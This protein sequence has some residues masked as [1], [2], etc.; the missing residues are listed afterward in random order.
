MK[1]M[2]KCLAVALVITL[3]IQLP[4]LPFL[5]DP[6]GLR[7]AA[8]PALSYSESDAEPVVADT[9]PEDETAL[10][11]TLRELANSLSAVGLYEYVRNNVKPEFTYGAS[12]GAAKTY[13]DLRG[14]DYDTA[15]LLIGLLRHKGIPARYRKG[16]V[17][18]TVPQAQGLTHTSSPDEAAK[19]LASEGVPTT[20]ITAQGKITA[21]RIERVWTECY[22]SYG[23]YRGIGPNRG[24]KSWIPLDGGFKL[25]DSGGTIVRHSTGL[26]PSAL[27][28]AVITRLDAFSTTAGQFIRHAPEIDYDIPFTLALG[29]SYE[30]YVAAAGKSPI[31][32]LTVTQNGQ[33]IALSAFGTFD[34]TAAS[35]GTFV[36]VLQATDTNGNQATITHTLLVVEE[37]DI[38][39]PELDV[40]LDPGEGKVFSPVGV[41]VDTRDDSG[42]VFVSVLVDGERVEGKNDVYTF[43]P[44][45][46]GAYEI[47]VT[48]TDPS[49]NY[50]KKTL[51]Y[52]LSAS[53]GETSASTPVLDVTVDTSQ[54]FEPGDPV[55]IHV[56]ATDESGAVTLVVTADGA[57]LSGNEGDYTFRPDRYG[58]FE[59]GVTATNIHGNSAYTTILVILTEGGGELDVTPP[60]LE[61][62]VN[63]QGATKIGKPVY[64]NVK[65]QDDSGEVTVDVAVNGQTLTGVAGSYVFTPD[66]TGRYDI[67]VTATD[68]SGN[69]VRRGA[70]VS[71][72]PSGGEASSYPNLKVQYLSRKVYVGETMRILIEASDA[73][74]MVTVAATADGEA[75]PYEDGVARF[76]PQEPGSF[77]IL[78]TA[79]N[80]SG[81]KAYSRFVVTAVVNTEKPHLFIV[82]GNGL[83]QADIGETVTVSVGGVGVSGDIALSADG[84]SLPLSAFGEAKFIPA[85]AGITTFVATAKD[86]YDHP[87]RAEATLK[88]LDP[89]NKAVPT[90]QI[91]APAEGAAVTA[92]TDICGTVSAEGLAYYTL[93][94]APV[95]SDDFTVI[96][97]DDHALS[98]G[99]LGRFDP[100]LLNNGYYTIRLTAIGAGGR[101]TDEITV[102]VQGEMKVG[103]FSLAFTDMSFAVRD[104]PLVV[105]RAYDSRNRGQSGD[106]GYG[107]SLALSGATLSTSCSLGEDWDIAVSAGPFGIPRYSWLETKA[108]EITVDWGNGQK[109]TFAMRLSPAYQDVLPFTYGVTAS[110]VPT[111]STTSKLTAV[112]ATSDLLYNGGRLL[113]LDAVSVFN[114]TRFKLTT[115]DGSVYVLS[116]DSGVES[117]TDTQ[118]NTITINRNG[119]YHSDGK[120]ISFVRDAKNRITKITGPTGKEVSYRYDESGNLAEVVDMTGNSTRFAYDRNHF[121]TDIVDPRGVR[122]AR[123]EYDDA[124][125][126]VAVIDASGNR[127]S[128]ENDVE[129]RRQAVTDRL[130]NT[131]LYIYDE[132]GKILS[133][134]DACGNTTRSAYDKNGNLSSQTDALGNMTTFEYTPDGKLL[135]K[136]NALGHKTA[137]AYNSKGFITSIS[138][139]DVTQLTISYDAKGNPVE[140]KGADGSKT[141]YAYDAKG[142]MTGVTDAI[143]Q[144]VRVGY[145]ADGNVASSTRADGSSATFAYDADGN[146]ISKTEVRTG[147]SGTET[148]TESYMYDNAGRLTQTILADGSVVA[149]QYNAIGKLAATV[150]EKGRRTTYSYDL[151]GNLER[152]SYADGTFESFEYDAEN[153]NTSATNRSSQTVSM[154]YDA[155][156]N[157]L[158][159]THQ[160]GA[161]ESYVY[162]EKYRLVEQTS[163]SG[164]VTRYEYD[165]ADRNTAV[166]DALGGRTEFVY[167]ATDQMTSMTDARGHTVSYEYDAN[168]K[169]TKVTF[170]DGSFMTS[171]YNVRGRVTSQTDQNGFVKHYEYDAADR[172][173][174]IT[175]PEGGI[176][177]YAYNETGNLVSVK[178]AKGN[179]TRYEYDKSGRVVKTTNAAGKT[180]T[181]QYDESGLLLSSTDYGGKKTTYQYDEQERLIRKEAGSLWA[182]FAYTRDGKLET[183]TDASGVTRYTYDE[184]DGLV[185]VEYPGGQTIR[186]TYDAARRLTGLQTAF[187]SVAYEYDELDRLIGVEDAAGKTTYRYD[188]TGNR[189][190]V[191]YPNGISMV[192]AYDTLNRLVRE[193]V[194]NSTGQIIASYVYTLGRSGER[195]QAEEPGRTVTYTYDKLYRLTTET[196]TTSEG[197]TLNLYEYDGVSNRTRKT[198]DDVVTN[199]SYNELNQLVSETGVTYTYDN[200]GNLVSQTGTGKNVSYEYDA[201]NRLMKATITE[202]GNTAVESYKYDCAGNRIEKTTNGVTT[203]YLV[204]TNTEYA[205]VIAELD[206][207]GSLKAF[208]TRGTELI[209][210]TAGTTALYYVY[211]GHGDTRML[212]D[213]DG[214]A[215]D[216]YVFD[217]WGNLLVR[218]GSTGNPFLYCGE[219]FDAA[220]GLY[221]LRARYMNPITGTFISM[222]TYQ[223]SVFDPQSLHKYLY[224]NSSPVMCKDPTG[225]YTLAEINTAMSVSSILSSMATYCYTT[226]LDTIGNF[227]IAS[228]NTALGRVPSGG[229]IDAKTIITT[230]TKV[231]EWI[232]SIISLAK[233]SKYLALTSV[234]L[235]ALGVVDLP[236]TW[237]V[238]STTVAVAGA[239]AGFLFDS[240]KVGI[241]V[242]AVS[243]LS[244]LATLIR[245]TSMNMAKVKALATI[246]HSG[247]IGG[248]YLRAMDAMI[249]GDRSA[250]DDLLFMA[251]TGMLECLQPMLPDLISSYILATS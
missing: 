208:Y 112:G 247:S 40:R 69:Y 196:V 248:Y 178:D 77:E 227:A 236:D 106:F 216:T 192:Y 44:E 193:E 55:T 191:T 116:V 125:R 184:M 175:D 62:V 102:S 29:E 203:R 174:K 127:M 147:E 88:V 187:G 113:D 172:L 240:P 160:N 73:S 94:Y 140:M 139:M 30:C 78:V 8:T 117:V 11:P 27:P 86:I 130:G 36:F 97:E 14:N 170:P 198:M 108:H 223:G 52:T 63:T 34:F 167:D 3:L 154:T 163:L 12:K 181:A 149:R 32:T 188:A 200:A 39:P 206:A 121:L 89:N 157:L 171:V 111:G 151:F 68:P 190:L 222:D 25:L 49:G 37:S 13:E 96:A 243:M 189:T 218:T 136:T 176:W 66:K 244:D 114:P 231:A 177:R 221:Y 65:A 220:T 110:F 33:P 199:Y 6:F 251:E 241:G 148:L 115:Q 168:G 9:V 186:Y 124:G 28:Y 43:T 158:T 226:V 232:V 82:V 245:S 144:F 131:T 31:K 103:H 48:A 90:A 23:N 58:V 51:T 209:S 156:G 4:G 128:F 173:V 105:S 213:K 242:S 152:I 195:L 56:T 234:V 249:H 228:I 72:M 19:V 91:T 145:D 153:R 215:T 2:K 155:M 238:V 183:A 150:D 214:V 197:K 165:T 212:T 16:I 230:S 104:F 194:K 50:T 120:S 57:E 169:R 46:P 70:T 53:G 235:A 42:Y 35:Y 224:C 142:Q 137:N 47:E 134:T 109:D 87:L 81:N 239:L 5:G 99:I 237:S 74:G 185:S 162:D 84:A 135:G 207:S 38:T 54:C 161:T 233:E 122:A 45:E 201:L 17:S 138:N 141:E 92:P 18:L 80:P 159:K 21:I 41:I 133:L 182:S 211:D 7:A 246:Y 204:D 119:V 67:V 93:S 20:I 76:I 123:N 229:G 79:T 24:E 59:I 95:G 101:E 146:C 166:I 250:V 179:E 132:R 164:G 143:G 10:S 126:L 26:L 61:V 225:M 217:A 210:R 205:Q 15:A 83:D 64:V 1:S 60:E 85:R 22:L 71:V 100:T 219:Q 98:N 118:G 129:G 75:L 180:F 107:W 202:G